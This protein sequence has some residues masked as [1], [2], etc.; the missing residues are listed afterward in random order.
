MATKTTTA[1]AATGHVDEG[2]VSLDGSGRIA[3]GPPPQDPKI[4]PLAQLIGTWT[5][6]G[7]NTIWRPLHGTNDHFLQLNLTSET[8]TFNGIGGPVPN[9][10]LAQKDI[11]L[12]GVRYL[13]QIHDNSGFAPPAG[14]G[15]LHLEPGFWLV[16]PATSAPKSGPTVA[17]LAS[18]PHGSSLLAEGNAVHGTGS[19]SIPTVDITPF[20]VGHPRQKVPFPQES[21]LSSK[22]KL[23]SAPL[24]KPITQALVNNPNKLLTDVLAKQKIQSFTQLSISSASGGSGLRNIAFLGTNAE[25]TDLT[26]TFWVEVVKNGDGS[27][28]RQLQ[29]TQTLMLNFN[30]LSWPHVTVA[31]LVL[32]GA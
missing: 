29:Y 27:T 31:T 26:A 9:R 8:L 11:N 13:Q 5:G 6:T 4:H 1:A 32:T 23:R 28:F 24:P 7:F 20:Q 12:S 30:G 10:G 19:P 21:K 18:I 17:R 2:A 22:S 15:A 16:V 14:G 3:A 25:A